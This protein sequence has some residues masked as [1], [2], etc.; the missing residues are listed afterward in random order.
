[1]YKKKILTD[2]ATIKSLKGCSLC[3]HRKTKQ[4]K[5]ADF[6]KKFRGFSNRILMKTNI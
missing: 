3:V 1:M 2:K 6:N 5:I 4:K